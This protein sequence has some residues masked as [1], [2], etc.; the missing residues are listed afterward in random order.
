MKYWAERINKIVENNN[1]SY[2]V[3]ASESRHTMQFENLVRM[4]VES[5]KHSL[6]KNITPA[7]LATC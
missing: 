6:D 5:H 2:L 7:H 4:L 1:Y 3:S